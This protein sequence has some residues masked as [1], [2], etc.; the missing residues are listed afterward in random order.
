[1]IRRYPPPPAGLRY[2]TAVTSLAALDA[3]LP[4]AQA[5][6]DELRALARQAT[7]PDIAKQLIALVKCYPSPGTADGEVYGR[8]L[9]EDVA[10]AQPAIGDL[11]GAC[12]NLRRTRKFIPAIAEV[13]EAI[14]EAK[15][16]RHDTMR[17]ILEITKSRDRL[18]NDVEKERQEGIYA[19]QHR[20]RY[21]PPEHIEE[22]VPL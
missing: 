4:E 15:N 16:H 21:S 12:R 8:L 2:H 9:M 1:M 13:L 18:L 3:V 5:L 19:D 20:I 11:E 22:G 17:K 14:G 7:K 6:L 10:A